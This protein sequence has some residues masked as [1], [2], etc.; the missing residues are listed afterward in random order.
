LV[1]AFSFVALNARLVIAGNDMGGGRRARR[2]VQQLGMADRTVFTGLLTG[3][4]RLHALA[5]ADVVVYASEHEV[6]GLV[7]FEALLAGTPVVV[8]NDSGCGDLIGATGGGHVVPVNDVHALARA[9]GDV[10]ARPADWRL[11]AARA[12]GYIRERYG[13]D[14]VCA[15]IETVYAEL[16][17]AR[18]EALSA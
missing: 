12:A 6:F 15:A 16:V 18:Q 8:A 1:R 10:L 14:S 2:L 3:V 17:T 9:I 11:R 7:P 4:D 13:E 5:D